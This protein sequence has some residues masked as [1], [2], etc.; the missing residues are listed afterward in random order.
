M[1]AWNAASESPCKAATTRRQVVHSKAHTAYTR[2]H[3]CVAYTACQFQVLSAQVQHL[4][5]A[6]AT[7]DVRQQVEDGVDVLH[8]R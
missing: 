4:L 8:S 7:Q 5:G 1:M 2:K 6:E 3:R